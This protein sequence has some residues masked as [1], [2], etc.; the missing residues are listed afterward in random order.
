MFAS[1]VL[2][3]AMLVYRVRGGSRVCEL[4]GRTMSLL[5]SLALHT[6]RS[7]RKIALT[8]N[9]FSLCEGWASA[10]GSRLHTV[11]TLSEIF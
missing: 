7:S 6:T 2:L 9:G 4:I 1:K 11:A 10:V 5:T 8:T 3:D